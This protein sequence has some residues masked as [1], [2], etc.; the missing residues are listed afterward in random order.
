MDVHGYRLDGVPATS[1]R[2]ADF[3]EVT[4]G[5]HMDQFGFTSTSQWIENTFGPLVYALGTFGT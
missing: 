1:K 3:F 2:I 4:V 5:L